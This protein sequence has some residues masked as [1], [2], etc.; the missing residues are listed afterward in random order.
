MCKMHTLVYSV[1]TVVRENVDEFEAICKSFTHPN[2]HFQK[3]VP[4]FDYNLHTFAPHV[5]IQIDG[6]GLLN[7]VQRIDQ[8]RA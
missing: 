5:M 3:N 8:S 1:K 4:K 2:L 7:H 6:C